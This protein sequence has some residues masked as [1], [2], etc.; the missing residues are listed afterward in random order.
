MEFGKYAFESRKR[1]LDVLLDLFAALGDLADATVLIGGW[2]PFFLGRGD[3]PAG[4]HIGSLDID[5]MVDP[6]AIKG[7]TRDLLD[8]LDAGRFYHSYSGPRFSFSRD[9]PRSGNEP[10]VVKLDLVSSDLYLAGEPVRYRKLRQ[11]TLRTARAGGISLVDPVGITVERHGM[12]VRFRLVNPVGFLVLKGMVMAERE[13]PKDFYDVH[14]LLADCLVPTP[15]IVEAVRRLDHPVILEGMRKIRAKFADAEGPGPYGV[16]AFLGEEGAGSRTRREAIVATL[17][18]LL[19]PLGLRGR[20]EPA[21]DTP[22]ID[23]SRVDRIG[24]FPPLSFDYPDL[25][26]RMLAAVPPAE[27]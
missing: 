23:F 10:L 14:A 20:P 11:L 6:E 19:L 22:V 3:A 1:A 15:A 27:G 26:G 4:A 2:V 18:R 8:R 24:D 9:V 17:D 12:P 16:L 7:R 21:E 13:R 5:L 25:V